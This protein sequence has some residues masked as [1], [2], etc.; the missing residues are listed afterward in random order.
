MAHPSI[1]ALVRYLGGRT[2]LRHARALT[3]LGW[4]S[5][6]AAWAAGA[7]GHPSLRWWLLAAGC[8]TL[9]LWQT[10][11]HPLRGERVCG[12]GAA[13]PVALAW[14]VLPAVALVAFTTMP[15]LFFVAGSLA[16][17]LG[18]A[19][20]KQWVA[21][22]SVLLSGVLR[23]GGVSSPRPQHAPRFLSS[24][25]AAEAGAPAPAASARRATAAN[26]RN[27]DYSAELERLRTGIGAGVAFEQLER[28]RTVGLG[29]YGKVM[30]VR[31]SSSGTPFA[32]KCLNRRLVVTHGQQRAVARERAVMAVVSHPFCARLVGSFK[33]AHAVYLLLEWCP[34]GELLRYLPRAQGEGLPEAHARF[35]ASCVAL[36]LEHLH[37]HGVLY[38]DVKP[39]NCL[40][41]GQGYLKLCDFGFAKRV[42]PGGASH[43]VCGTPDFMAP[44]VIRGTGHGR[45]ADVWSLGVLIYELVAGRPPFGERGAAPTAIYAAV[46]A[47]APLPRVPSA[48][49]YFS[50]LVDA[51]LVAEPDGR[52]GAQGWGAVKEHPWFG[53]LDWE[54]L[55][56]RQLPPPI[57][58]QL[59]GALDTRNFDSFPD[60]AVAMNDTREND[61]DDQA[62]RDAALSEEELFGSWDR[63][64]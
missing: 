52:V 28:G 18:G 2:Q 32:L 33:D 23:D 20:P 50:A 34:G 16:L 43:T 13:E 48:S 30:L 7:A 62:P 37:A 9:V 14:A 42:G 45:M 51:L 15:A 5:A 35:F 39:E 17:L 41:D 4:C 49:A 54:A 31:H 58:P 61:D 38:R 53:E 46:L 56:Q 24:D 63:A 27:S 25:G 40:L 22:A 8:A 11:L 60:N 26:P 47:H 59:S 44:E 19:L 6:T 55:E 3:L 36:A 64:F 21:Q 29:S 57:L 1:D 10:G 12:A